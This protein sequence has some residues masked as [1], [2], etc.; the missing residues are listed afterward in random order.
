MNHVYKIIILLLTLITLVLT[1]FGF[2]MTDTKEDLKIVQKQVHGAE[3]IEQ[4][5]LIVIHTEAYAILSQLNRA[6]DYTEPE[7]KEAQENFK[8]SISILKNLIREFPEYKTPGLEQ[9][10]SFLD[11]FLTNQK[12]LS[13]NDFHKL[14]GVLIN[15]RDEIFNIGDIATLH[16]EG[17]KDI[18][19]FASIMTHYMPEFIGELSKTRILLTEALVHKDININRR[20]DII[21]SLGLFTLSK[22]EIDQIV[23]MIASEYDTGNLQVLLK[24]IDQSTYDMYK[25]SDVILERKSSSL[26]PL[27]FYE[28]TQILSKLSISIHDENARL[29][30]NTLDLRSNSLKNKLYYINLAMV[31]IIVLGLLAI[32]SFY[33]SVRTSFER[34]VFTKNLLSQAQDA[35][36]AFTL[37]CKMDLDGSISSVNK[38]FCDISGYTQEE[39]VGRSYETI[40][41]PDVPKKIFEEMWKRIQSKKIWT[42][43]IK[44]KKKDAEAFYLDMLIKPIMDDE[45]NI[46]EYISISSDITELEIIKTQLESDLKA[47]NTSLYESYMNARE[48]QQL[49]EDQKELY[50]L[51]FKN[52]ASSVLIIDIEENKFIDCNEP[53]I[54]ILRC[55]SKDD[56]LNLMPAELSPEFQPDGRRSDEK[57]EEMNAIAVEHGSHTFEWKHLAKDGTEIWVEVILTPILLGHKKVLHV[58]WKDISEKKQAAK[59]REEQQMFMIQQSRL[60]S[61]GEMIGNISHQWRQPLNALGLILQKLSIY[62]SRGLLD[63]EKFKENFDKSMNLINSMSHTIN[64]F[65]DFFNPNKEKTSFLVEDAIGKAYNIVE[66]SFEHASIK[67]RL[68]TDDNKA[69]IEGYE[70]EFSQ[71]ILNLLNNAKDALVENEVSAKT[72]IVSIKKENGYINISVSDNAG[73]IPEKILSK[74]FEPYFTTKEEGKGTGIGLYMSKMIIDDHMNGTL[75]VSNSDEG[76]CFS[77]RINS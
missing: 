8:N 37:V 50:E 2:F 15:L 10:I 60:A 72:V 76:A 42:G 38:K 40:G 67:Y 24:Q 17:E 53:A 70:N 57:S 47:S 35:N 55:D 41:H 68:E 59:E 18:Y 73:G 52:T 61:M 25:I 54:D 66:S 6:E 20:N 64:D 63:D 56:V 69:K 27:K 14:D 62:Q 44:S 5:Q 33:Y 9:S 45:N 12:T 13:H 48:Q 43:K 7:I 21:H 11:N 26:N 74:I 51:V 75:A 29:L 34:E 1:M 4:I 23:K 65:R 39:V 36:D 32:V 3:V 16:Y 28:Q 49:L 71:V 31:L 19:L 22:K 30:S 58:V 77:I 46:I